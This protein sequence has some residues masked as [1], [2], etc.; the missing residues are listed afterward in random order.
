MPAQPHYQASDNRNEL[1]FL[2]LKC[3][4]NSDGISDLTKLEKCNIS[5]VIII[6]KNLAQTRFYKLEQ[7][8]RGNIH[9]D[10]NQCHYHDLE[11]NITGWHTRKSLSMVWKV[12]KEAFWIFIS[13][14][15]T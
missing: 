4:Y 13:I 15:Q 12:G 1:Q 2:K 14:N 8:L 7:P 10:C 5:D 3:F 9:C 11:G 6:L